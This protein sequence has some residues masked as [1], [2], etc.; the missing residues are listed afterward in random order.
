MPDTKTPARAAVDSARVGSKR[1]T[2]RK[3]RVTTIM[4]P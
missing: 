1:Q 4:S 3:G 2:A